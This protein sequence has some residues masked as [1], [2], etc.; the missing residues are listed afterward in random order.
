LLIQKLLDV[1]HVF[2]VC[3]TVHPLTAAA[4]RRL[5]LGELRFPKA[6]HVAGEATEA[7]DFADAKIELVRDDNFA[8]NGFPCVSLCRFVHDPGAKRLNGW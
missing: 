7:A 4:L 6:Q 8:A 3:L 1:N 5:Q 2:H